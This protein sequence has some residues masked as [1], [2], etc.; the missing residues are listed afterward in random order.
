MS[1]YGFS[2]SDSWYGYLLVGKYLLSVKISINISIT[3]SHETITF[4][5]FYRK[6]WTTED[7]YRQVEENF[8][9]CAFDNKASR[10]SGNSFL[11]AKYAILS[12]LYNTINF[13]LIRDGL[14]ICKRITQV[15]QSKIPRLEERYHNHNEKYTVYGNLYQVCTNL[16]SK[17]C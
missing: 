1:L 7:L 11:A 17:A 2:N 4:C 16:S 15:R 14:K 6:C 13:I 5:F 10:N 8:W 9:K 12:V 3:R